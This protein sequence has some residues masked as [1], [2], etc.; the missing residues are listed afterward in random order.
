MCGEKAKGRVISVAFKVHKCAQA[1]GLNGCIAVGES[2]RFRLTQ[3]S[4]LRLNYGFGRAGV[5]E[6]ENIFAFKS[7]VLNSHRITRL[8]CYLF[9]NASASA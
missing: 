7:R 1:S 3:L 5:E 6:W 2:T 8:V 4:T 9:E